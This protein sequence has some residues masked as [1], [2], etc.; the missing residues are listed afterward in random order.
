MSDPESIIEEADVPEAAA[1][2]GEV[3]EDDRG[4]DE[5]ID[6]VE[7]EVPVADAVEQHRVVRIDEDEYR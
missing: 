6:E 3:V 4:D 5:P 1:E 7:L 2:P